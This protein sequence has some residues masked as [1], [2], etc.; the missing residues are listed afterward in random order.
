MDCR[1]LPVLPVYGLKKVVKLLESG[2]KSV[3]IRLT[4][5]LSVA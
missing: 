2:Y 4:V 3:Y 5:G 1:A